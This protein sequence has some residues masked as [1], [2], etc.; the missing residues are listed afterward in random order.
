MRSNDHLLTGRL[1]LGGLAVGAALVALG[2]SPPAARAQNCTALMH[3]S[4]RLELWAPSQN[5]KG[6]RELIAQTLGIP[7]DR[8]HVNLTRIGGGFGRRLRHD[9]MVEAAEFV[10]VLEHRQNEKI[11]CIEEVAFRMGYITHDQLMQ[12]AIP[13]QKTAYGAY[14]GQIPAN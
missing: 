4:G 6:G 2:G 13:L 8:I 12:L 3:E 5:P 9:S 14:I 11:S 1:G 7:E 10:R